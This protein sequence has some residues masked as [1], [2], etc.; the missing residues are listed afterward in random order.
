MPATETIESSGFPLCFKVRPG[1]ARS[2]LIAGAAGTRASDVFLAEARQI[3]G[4]QK[5]CVV[6]EG[7]RGNVFRAVSDE[8]AQLRGT[9]LAPFP[10][11]FYNAGLN[12]DLVNRVLS[13]ARAR[14]ITLNDLSIELH[15]RYSMT[16]SF[17]KGTGV[18]SAEPA[19]IKVRVASPATS[20]QIEALVRDAAAASPALATMRV[21]LT[22]TFALYVNGRR[23]QVTTLPASSSPDAADPFVTYRTPPAPLEGAQAPRDLVSKTGATTPGEF[24]YQVAETKDRVLINVWGD[25]RLRDPQG[26]TETVV[27]LGYPR[28]SHF[29]I[30][31]DEPAFR[32]AAPSGL[33][34]VTA[35]IVFCYITQLL[36]Y[37]EHQKLNIRGVR[38]VQSSP[39]TLSA[40]GGGWNGGVEPVDTHLFLN[41]EASDE[42][43]E[44]LM[45]VAAKTCYLHATLGLTLP[46]EITVE[47]GEQAAA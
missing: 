20:A 47:H 19:L 17:F 24:A 11:G 10:L 8:G 14:S 15:N 28:T 13:L 34:Y 16:G 7:A 37:I 45:T 40:T 3:G 23:R 46:P 22:N 32:D 5:E 41:G 26:V 4:H 6:H 33:S 43:F 44:K 25:C 39:Y 31:S 36:R 2:V 29:A 30:R 9:D 35:G 42:T 38:V 12:A 21:P 27:R 1:K 18:G